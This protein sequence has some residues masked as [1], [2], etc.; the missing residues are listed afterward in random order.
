MVQTRK[1]VSFL[2]IVVLILLVLAAC[3]DTVSPDEHFQKGNEAAQAGDYEQAIVEFEAVLEKEPENVS[4]MS[5]L[6]VVYYN[7][8]RLDEA[9]EQYQK[10]IEIA[11]EDADI[12]SNLAAAYVQQNQLDKGLEEYQAAVDLNPRLAEAFFGLGVVYLQ[13]GDADGA[14]QAFEK[15]QELDT[16]KDPMATDLAEQYLEQLKGP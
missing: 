15:F 13:T 16:G 9:I 11:P 6:G 14:I 12:H 1:L 8:G 4:A 5:N 2:S 7:L 10:A 3:G